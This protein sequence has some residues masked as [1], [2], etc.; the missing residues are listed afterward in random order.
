MSYYRDV[1]DKLAFMTDITWTEWSVVNKLVLNYADDT[2]D[3]VTT[4]AWNDSF[5]YSIGV[6]YQYNDKYK[7]RCGL[8]YDETPISSEV[9]RE[10]RVPDGDRF[11]ITIGAS[12]KFSDELSLE[13]AYAY[14]TAPNDPVI[15]K[16]TLT[17]S[18][19][20]VAR[21]LLNGQYDVTVNIVSVQLNYNFE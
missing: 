8:A 5:R 19:E 13:A 10:V 9:L 16:R 20:D 12:L 15:D 21:G 6:A 1:S 2:N 4:L 17:P 11:W 3:S 7:L 14:V 18:T